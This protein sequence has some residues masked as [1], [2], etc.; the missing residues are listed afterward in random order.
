MPDADSHSF[1][2]EPDLPMTVCG[3]NLH[4]MATGHFSVERAMIAI[5]RHAS[6][7]I[8]AAPSSRHRAP[9]NLMRERGTDRHGWDKWKFSVSSTPTASKHESSRR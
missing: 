7:R 3:T 8:V 4:H 6:S 9:R 5:H 1:G 2:L